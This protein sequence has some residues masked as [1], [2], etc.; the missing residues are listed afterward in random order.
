MKHSEV[1]KTFLTLAGSLAFAG[2]TQAATY[3]T[4]FF[5]TDD[6]TISIS[7][8]EILWTTGVAS[9]NAVTVSDLSDLSISFY[10]ESN[11]LV[12]T[13]HAIS[14]GVEQPISGI[15]RQA[16]DIEFN[17][18]SGT[19][20]SDF[21]NATA[22][23]LLDGSSGTTYNIYGPLANVVNFGRYQAGTF[24]DNTEFTV[25][26]QNTSAVP[27]P[28]SY[29]ALAGLAGLGLAAARRRRA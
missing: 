13:D 18:T 14:G 2:T 17:A 20:I 29:A 21:D 24:A 3:L 25:T 10:D 4:T 28:S 27:E 19:S 8:I 9:G 16:G 22:A 12:F 26:S 5:G 23:D 1:L 6:N 15:N 11:A 7:R